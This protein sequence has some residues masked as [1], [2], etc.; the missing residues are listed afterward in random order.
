M[1]Y[2]NVIQNVF[3]WL[4]SLISGVG[5]LG[6]FLFTPMSE[7]IQTL[8]LPQWISDALTWLVGIFGNNISPIMIIGVIG[9]SIAIIV[10]VVKAFV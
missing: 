3:R 10:G 5:Q 6:T 8:T 7:S 9:I 4:W 1:N 2:N